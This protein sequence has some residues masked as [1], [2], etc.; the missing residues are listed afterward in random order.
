[1]SINAYVGLPGSGKSYSV[2]EH[3]VLPALKNG[4]R[5]WTNIPLNLEL[6]EELGYQAPVIFETNEIVENPK[7]F[8]EIF[9]AGATII[10]DECWRFWPAGTK[11][12]NMEMGH[13]SFFSEHRHMVGADGN[14]T[15]IALITQ[16]L[17]QI[18]A[19]VRNL[20]EFT[21][22]SVKLNAIGAST[23]FRVD[24]YQGAVTGPK[25]PES[26]RLRQ[27][28]GSYKP[29]VYRLYQSQTMNQSAEH[30]DETLTDDR[31]NIF[32]SKLLKIGAPIALAIG[33]MFIWN[34]MA[35]VNEMYS[36]DGDA[37][38]VVQAGDVRPAVEVIEK[39][40]LPDPRLLA[41]LHDRNVEIVYNN[42]SYPYID[43]IF[44]LSNEDSAATFNLHQ[45]RS[46]GFQ[47]EAISQCLVLLINESA[48]TRAMC[49]PDQ[50]ETFNDSEIAFEST[51]EFVTSDG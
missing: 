5:V 37:E 27:L 20:V 26:Q 31:M 10:I 4:R 3:V 19:T 18:A 6:I 2:V 45:L 9:E 48:I 15:E 46:M 51:T 1:M 43:Y 8:Q 39:I 17:S 24:I 21:N 12:S 40:V 42:G 22:R 49:R 32:N 41:I 35:A 11:A 34:S 28:F 47:I 44:E 29:E 50:I 7:F 38:Q 25:P 14:S 36:G 33:G 13:K 23:K 30:G 16:D